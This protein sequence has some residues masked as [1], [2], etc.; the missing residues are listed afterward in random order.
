M[1][2]AQTL[3]PVLYYTAYTK[4]RCDKSALR[5]M[6]YSSSLIPN[7][8]SS[9]SLIEKYLFCLNKPKHLPP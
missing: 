1:S 6:P 5:P 3:V 2:F 9:P 7:L 4:M 8:L